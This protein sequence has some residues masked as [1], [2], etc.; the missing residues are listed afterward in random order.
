VPYPVVPFRLWGLDFAE[1]MLWEFGDDPTYGM[2]EIARVQRR[3]GNHTFFAL[4]SEKGGRQH[5]GIGDPADMELAAAFPAPAYDAQLR[6]IR[7]HSA[8][9]LSYDVAFHLPDGRMVQG[10]LQG[11]NSHPAP[12][13]RNGNAMNHSQDSVLAVLDLR[14]MGLSISTVYV[15]DHWVP[16]RVLV[17]FVPY[18]MRLVQSVGGMASGELEFHGDGDVVE[19]QV[20]GAPMSFRTALGGDELHFIGSDPL[21]DHI[22]RY[23]TLGDGL[24]GPLELTDVFVK[25][26]EAVVFTARFNP[27]L[28]DLRWPLDRPY[29]SR[30]MAGA[31][32]SDDSMVGAITL[33]P[34]DAGV[35]VDLIP[36]RHAWACERPVRTTITLGADVSLSAVIDP[37]LAAGGAG[38]EGC[39][40][41]Q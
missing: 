37:S 23:R 26:G 30:V 16:V 8:T 13:E 11:K 7:L 41:L 36:E 32:T 22:Y 31:H 21:V 19:A 33:T 38:P 6:V 29:T 2:V 25:H 4:V 10:H 15:D 17:P 3:D 35:T 39:A 24:D 14:E 1:E 27:P 34:T 5:V 20:G 12:K 9:H 18:S 40:A 28:P